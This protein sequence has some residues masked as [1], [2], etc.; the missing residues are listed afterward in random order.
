ML[1]R[2][3]ID[4]LKS[5][6][7]TDEMIAAE[8]IRSLSAG[9]HH[10]EGTRVPCEADSLCWTARAMSGHVIGYQTRKI[11]EHD[12][13]WW[14]AEK[15]QHLPI[16]YASREDHEIL[17]TTGK[18]IMTEG[19]FDRGAIK[20]CFPEYAVYARLSKGIAK[21]LLTYLTRYGKI[22][23]LAFDQDEPG[24]KAAAVATERLTGKV[25]VNTLQFPYKDPALFLEKRGESR[26]RS[27]LE[28]QIRALEI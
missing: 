8:E 5:R 25:E 12:Y 14:Q 26:M 17:Y 28:K 23:W 7:Y 2:E 24:Q 20:R 18:V 9:E 6:T 3:A 1:T 15:S 22:V 13:K 11:E 27:T 19:I 21:Q 10:I 4:Y 16:I